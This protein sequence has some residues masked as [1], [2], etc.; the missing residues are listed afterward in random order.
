MSNHLRGK[1]T[2]VS[3]PNIALAKYWGKASYGHNLPAVPSLSVTLEGMST[4]TSVEFDPGLSADSLLLNGVA[5]GDGPTKRI[6]SLLDRVRREVGSSTFARVASKNDFPT[7]S[8]LASS[9]SAFSALAVA[10]A[11][12]AGLEM[13]AAALSDLARQ[14]SVSSARSVLG[15]FVELRAGTEG[16]TFLPAVQV[17][18]QDHWDLAVVVAVTREGPKDV[19]S[20]EGMAHTAK[21]SPY[22]RGWVESAP[23]VFE[24]VRAAVVARDLAMLGEAAEESALAMHAAAIAARPSVLYFT[25]ATVEA[26]HGCAASALRGH[27]P[28]S[29]STPAPT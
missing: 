18:P 29:P 15:G 17:A 2:V 10:A 12:A 22:F 3:H 23:A 28:S 9:A 8:G 13:D 26:I 20:S 14:A 6:T 7:A 5:G 1:A 27:P 25:G 21:T 4:E 16:Q 11:K 24:R 19:G